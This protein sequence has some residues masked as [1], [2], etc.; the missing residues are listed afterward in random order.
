MAS[1]PSNPYIVTMHHKDILCVEPKDDPMLHFPVG[2]LSAIPPNDLNDVLVMH[3]VKRGYPDEMY[4]QLVK[5]VKEYY[6]TTF[7]DS[8]QTYTIERVRFNSRNYPYEVLLDGSMLYITR[9]DTDK[10]QYLLVCDLG[11]TEPA[12]VSK[13]LN[14][15]VKKVPNF[16]GLLR[17]DLVAGVRRYYALDLLPNLVFHDKY[18]E[19]SKD[20]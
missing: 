4:P 17:H 18:A 16:Q 7:F 19:P 8:L 14:V 15:M 6:R 11:K 10:P 3:A 9:I 12:K 2:N 5:V 13:R 1:S 20:V